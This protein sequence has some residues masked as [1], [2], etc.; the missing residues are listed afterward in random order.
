MRVQAELQDGITRCVM[1]CNPDQIE[2]EMNDE[3][4]D[5]GV[6]LGDTIDDVKQ[7]FSAIVTHLGSSLFPII[8]QIAD[9][10]IA[11]LPQIECRSKL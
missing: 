10:I 4:V 5:S 3:A 9:F 7:S 1:Y 6:R 8:Q 11:N 2:L